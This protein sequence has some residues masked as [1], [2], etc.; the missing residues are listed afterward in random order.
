M[1]KPEIE[2]TGLTGCAIG[3]AVV[4]LLTKNVP[5]NRDNIL[6]ELERMKETSDELAVK[7]ITQDAAKLLRKAGHT[8][9]K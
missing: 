1:K 2:R 3:T 7:A 8:R 6:Y 9:H 5:L 4:E